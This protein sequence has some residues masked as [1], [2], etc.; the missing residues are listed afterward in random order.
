MSAINVFQQNP[1]AEAKAQ[2]PLHHADLASLVG[3]GRKN[4]GVTLRE[5]K[6]LGHITLRGDGHNP[7][8]AAGVHKALGLELPVALTVVANKDMSLQWV[9]PD[10]WLLIV[11]GGQELAA[12]QK[13]RAALEG[14]HIQVVNVSGGQS[15]LELRGPNVRDVLM[16]S[17]SYDVHPN[18][19]PVGKA[20]GTVF[21]K[22]QL[23]IRRTAEDTWELVI[24]R[25]FADYWWL[26]LQDASAEYGLSI[27]A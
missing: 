8:F 4:A 21:A 5:R 11:P 2:S 18:N 13:L 7:E 17:T 19:F 22:S 14:Q 25:S 16:K 23:V 15:L 10:E 3:K 24:R 12:E 27:E 1:G 26:W 6:F 9:G 20:V